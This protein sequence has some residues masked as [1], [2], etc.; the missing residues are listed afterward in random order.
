MDKG[1][2]LALHK[3]ENPMNKNIKK[4]FNLITNQGMQN[5]SPHT[6]E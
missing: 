3:G 5:I 1:L 6:S 2:K 4:Q